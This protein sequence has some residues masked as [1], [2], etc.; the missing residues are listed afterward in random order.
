MA[1]QALIKEES[2]EL[3]TVEKVLVKEEFKEIVEES[4]KERGILLISIKNLY[5]DLDRRCAFLRARSPFPNGYMKVTKRELRTSNIEKLHK[6]KAHYE[7]LQGKLMKIQKEEFPRVP[8]FYVDTSAFEWR[9]Q[10]IS[11][12]VRGGL[13]TFL[14]ALIK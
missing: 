13:L 14:E 9:L 5:K 11:R 7:D 2:K 8:I 10:E 6:V 12:R 1:E 3:T 4:R